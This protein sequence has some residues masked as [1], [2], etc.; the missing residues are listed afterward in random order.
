M[1]TNV[2]DGAARVESIPTHRFMTT[3]FSIIVSANE[4]FTLGSHHWK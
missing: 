3:G 1:E 2:N 4:F